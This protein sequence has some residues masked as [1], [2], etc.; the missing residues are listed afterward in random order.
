MRVLQVHCEFMPQSSGVARHM[1]G[2]SQALA[3]LGTIQPIIYAPEIAPP[4]QPG[5]LIRKGGAA[6]LAAAVRDC[7]VV[8]AHGSRT[9][10]S[11][12]A[13][14]LGR[15]MDKPVVYTPHCYYQGGGRLRQ[16]GKTLWD[17]SVEQGS[18]AGADCVILLHEEW[19]S[20]LQDH[21][22]R[23]RRRVVIPNCIEAEAFLSRLAATPPFRLDGHPAVLSIGRLDKV[24]RLDDAIRALAQPGLEQAQLH[25]VGQ[26]NDRAR[27]QSLSA[28]KGLAGRVHFHG[29]RSDDETAAMMQGCHAM[30]LAS[31]RE[32]L[33]TVVLEALLAAR[34]I[35]LSDI[36]GNRAIADAVG[37]RCIFPLGD[38]RA[39]AQ[40][41]VDCV[42]TPVT[43]AIA[44]SV[45][46]GF[47]WRSRI[48]DIAAL[49]E[50]LADRRRGKR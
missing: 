30:V 17:G 19:V 39:L 1:A 21:G 11:A 45:A 47:G 43:E 33:P 4:P 7:D 49:Y 37:W 40:C 18:V 34:P 31:E 26:G 23:P 35:A 46:S 2:L 36:E 27:L 29:W 16:W 28:D 9:I 3:E 24:K 14:R 32:G 12:L 41:L 5:Y 48:A 38:H 20:W 50:D 15:L 25:I 8:H 6:G 10:L 13:I 44:Q 22:L 42:T